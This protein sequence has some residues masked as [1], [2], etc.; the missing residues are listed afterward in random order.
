[1]TSVGVVKYIDEAQWRFFFGS[2][3]AAQN[4]GKEGRSKMAIRIP[5]RKIVVGLSIITLLLIV[6][7]VS[8]QIYKFVINNGTDRYLTTMFSFDA[9]HNFPT[10]F[11]TIIL[12]ICS[13][14][15][16]VIGES[17]KDPRD[18]FRWHW[19]ILGFVFFY[20]ATDEMLVLHE[21][22][23][24]PIKNALHTSGFFLFAWVIPAGFFLLAFLLAYRKFLVELP[25]RFRRLFILSGLIYIA[26]AVV[27]ELIGGNFASHSGTNNLFYALLTNLEEAFEMFGTIVFIHA[28]FSYI[29]EHGNDLRFR[30]E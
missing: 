3:F 25:T 22:T 15:L 7:S 28:L 14:L 16:I 20:L 19:S 5:R 8:S 4:R 10:F 6:L 12:L 13:L 11:S 21:Q 29:E 18:K 23:I 26:G 24:G 17:K 2:V 30:V 1:M 27:M 9:E